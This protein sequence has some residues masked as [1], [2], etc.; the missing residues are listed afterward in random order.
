MVDN[1]TQTAA[2]LLNCFDVADN[3][4]GHFI[5]I[6]INRSKDSLKNRCKEITRQ[7]SLEKFD[8]IIFSYLRGKQFHVKGTCIAN[9]RLTN[10]LTICW[11]SFESNCYVTEALM[12]GCL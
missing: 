5:V 1:T 4:L 9:T 3:I 11:S 12:Y 7:V 2:Q 6:P 10:V 8:V